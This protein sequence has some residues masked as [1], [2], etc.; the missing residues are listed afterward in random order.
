[1]N[2]EKAITARLMKHAR[3]VSLLSVEHDIF[4]DLK[5][6]NNM[7]FNLCN[8]HIRDFMKRYLDTLKY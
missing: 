6:S 7:I 1:M 2:L 3:K 4:K 8:N 5:I